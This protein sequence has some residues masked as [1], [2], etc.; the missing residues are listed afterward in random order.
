MKKLFILTASLLVMAITMSGQNTATRDLGQFSKI[1]VK[2]GILVQLVKAESESAEINTQG[3]TPDNVLTEVADGVLTLRL[4]KTSFS[5]TKVMVKLFYKQIVSIKA[6]GKSEISSSA[7][8]KQDSLTIDLESGAKVYVDIDIKFL[9]SNLTEGALI[10]AEGYA[11]R[12][13]ATVAT[14]ATLSLFDVESD[15]IDVKVTSNAK[16]KIQVE[17]TLVADVS[18]GGYLSFKG[19]PASKVINTS[20]GGKV[21]QYQE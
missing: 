9:K 10:A 16:A 13:E 2:N 20:V 17:K 11:V 8:M 6:S 12:Q 21:E 1:E 18:T 3:T 7:L 19:N 14:G 15:E 5:R 4:E